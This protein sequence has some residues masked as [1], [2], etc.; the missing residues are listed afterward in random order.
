MRQHT[1]P[2]PKG[3]LDALAFWDAGHGLALGDP[4]GGR[5]V[6]FSTDD[7]GKTWTDGAQGMPAALPGEGEF[8]ASGTCLVVQR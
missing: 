5:F 1:N 6:I 2:D 7:A 8:A 4:V 3:F